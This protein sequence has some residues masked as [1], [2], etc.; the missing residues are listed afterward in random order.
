MGNTIIGTV[1]LEERARASGPA[2]CT[3]Q[4]R[5]GAL[6]ALHLCTE[7]T[8]LKIWEGPHLGAV[9]LLESWKVEKLASVKRVGTFS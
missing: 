6:A 9:P 1:L 3:A 2:A 8:G 7:G 5:A 4:F